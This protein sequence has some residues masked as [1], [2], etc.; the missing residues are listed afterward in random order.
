MCGSQPAVFG[1][2]HYVVF[3]VIA[4]LTVTTVVTPA[5]SQ[6]LSADDA[7]LREEAILAARAGNYPESLAALEALRVAYPEELSLAHDHITVLAWSDDNTAVAEIAESLAPEDAPRYAQLAVAKAVRNVQRFGLAASWYDAAIAS[8]PEDTDALSGRLLTAADAGDSDTVLTLVA[9]TDALAVQNTQLIVA[10]AYALLAIGKTLEALFAYQ[11][12]LANEPSHPEALRGKALVLRAMLLPTQALELAVLHPGILTDIEMERLRA[13]ETVIGL[14]LRART[15]YPAPSLYEN[16]DRSIALIDRQIQASTTPDG[17]ETLLRD[18][19]VALIDASDAK[20][21]VDQ[22]EALQ[23][24]S[25]INEAYVLSAASRAYFQLR[26]PQQGIEL[27]ERAIELDPD[28]VDYKFALVYAFLDL[29][30]FGEALGLAQELTRSLPMV[31]T[32]PGSNIVK[33]NPHRMRAELLAGLAEAH[34][35]QLDAAQSRFE[36]LLSEAPNNADLRHELANVYRWRGWYDRS[37]EEYRQVLTMDDEHL[38]AELGF[39]HSRIDAQDYPVVAA[40]VAEVSLAHGR[41][42]AVERLAERWQVHNERELS[43]RMSTGDSTGPI[44][45]S[46]H[47][48]IDARWYT[49]PIAYHYRAFVASYDSFGE[50]TEGESRR[51]RLGAGI[52]Y[53]APRVTITG[54]LSGSRSGSRDAGFAG[55]LNYRLNDFWSLNAGI[56]WNSD[57][58]QL[59]AHRFGIKADRASVGAR[60]AASELASVDFGAARLDYSDGNAIDSFFADGRFRLINHPRSKLEA[61][62]NITLG[63]ADSSAVPYFS[64]TRDRSATAGLKHEYRIFRRYDRK[65]TQTIGAATGRY[66]QTGFSSGSIWSVRYQ[67]DLSL[68][69]RLG[70]GFGA[71]RHGQVF[72]GVH[73]HT[74]IGTIAVTSRF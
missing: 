49:A 4:F 6:T 13:D 18:R 65:L 14:R 21:A 42:P 66:F 27:L 11:D 57:K 24:D 63:L 67:I 46:D 45:G 52:E 47:Y 54:S 7:I 30:R 16:R 40:T 5:N 55:G 29:E 32:V 53:R 71:E 50:F 19:I 26:Q 44:S 22:F 10:R 2:I 31:N 20:A 58:V 48:S 39:A 51:R 3:F 74:T 68:S 73:E 9:D 25:E 12:V 1:R 33:G 23:S 72:D 69:P 64:P 17:R 36:A 61:T 60:F 28:N 56:E 59:R 70:V 8:D 62:G 15:P 43:V 37:L 41:V 38:S 34:G 35:D